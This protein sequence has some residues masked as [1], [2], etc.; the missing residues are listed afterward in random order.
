MTFFG[1]AFNCRINVAW[2]R[3]ITWKFGPTQTYCRQF[4][5]HVAVPDIVFAE[6]RTPFRRED[7]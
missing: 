6:H 2:F 4:R 5:L 7:E 3:P 1:S